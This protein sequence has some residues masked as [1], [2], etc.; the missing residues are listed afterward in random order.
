M[1]ITPGIRNAFERKANGVRLEKI[2]EANGETQFVVYVAKLGRSVTVGCTGHLTPKQAEAEA[3][4]VAAYLSTL[5]PRPAPAARD[6]MEV[7][8]VDR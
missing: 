8:S 4:R 5:A 1:N 2:A 6:R 7:A 3:G